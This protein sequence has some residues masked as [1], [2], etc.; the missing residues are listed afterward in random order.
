MAEEYKWETPTI[1]EIW[2]KAAENPPD[3]PYYQ[4]LVALAQCKRLVY[5]RLDEV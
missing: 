4:K 3:A 5:N 1:K 2:E